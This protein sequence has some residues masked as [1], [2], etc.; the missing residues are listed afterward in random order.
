MARGDV[1]TPSTVASLVDSSTEVARR[2]VSPM[3]TVPKL[4]PPG[5]QVCTAGPP[6]NLRL[7]FVSSVQAPAAPTVKSPD[8]VIV[9][10]GFS[11]REQIAQ[12]TDRRALHLAQVV[13]LAGLQGPGGPETPYPER[14]WVTSGLGEPRPRS[15]WKAGAVAVGALAAAAWLARAAAPRRTSRRFAR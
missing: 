7:L 12:H 14:G 6:S 15:A 5:I 4:R 1:P 2:F 11:C 13:R 9:A 3:N 8:T 10:D